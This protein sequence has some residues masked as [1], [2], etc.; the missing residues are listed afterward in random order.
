MTVLAAGA[1]DAANTANT[2]NTA[3]TADTAGAVPTAPGSEP[4]VAYRNEATKR[5][6]APS[7]ARVKEMSAQVGAEAPGA[8]AVEELVALGLRE[9][10]V[11]V[12][13]GGVKL[14]LRGGLRSAL[15]A[16]E[17][18]GKVVLSCEG[19]PAEAEIP[20]IASAGGG[21]VRP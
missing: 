18:D 16:E 20:S 8:M 1:A 10:A 7:A 9:E 21:E 17:R 3:D 2:A 5:F 19:A 6:E 14:R 12:P 4:S 15:L 11:A 13:A